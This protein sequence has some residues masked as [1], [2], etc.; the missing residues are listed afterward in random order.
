MQLVVPNRAPLSSEELQRYSRHLILPEVGREGQERL[1]AAKVLLVG[2]GGL[3]SPVAIYLAA[4]GVG[5]IGMVDFDVVDASNLQRQVL[6]FTSDVGK[7]KLQS[8]CEK[9]TAL[10]PNLA[11]VGH[12]TRLTTS[13]ALEIVRGYDVV[14][15]GTDNFP[16]RY[17]VNDACVLSKKPNVYGS[18]YRFDGMAS[19][20]APHLG[21][22]CYRCWYPE[23]PPAG[24]VPSCAEAGVIGVLPGVIGN[25]QA[26][27][28]IKLILGAGEPLLGRLL[29]FNALAMSFREHRIPRDP[30]CP[31][32][33]PNPTIIELK[34][35]P[36]TCS[37]DDISVEQLKAMRERKEDFVLVDV[38]DPDEFAVN[39]IA[40]S[41]KLPLPELPQR[42]GELPKSKLL[43]LHCKAGGRSARALKFL[44]EQGYTRLR[45]LAGGITAWEQRCRD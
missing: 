22:P 24:A 15:D 19:V 37:P 12:E 38:R 13:N 5:T 31:L 9:L 20:F 43:V 32:C 23:P 35:I 7:P 11:F 33:G 27:E 44:R 25:I 2:A 26:T 1:K 17:L 3:G 45:N 40:G 10:N 36:M 30:N 8:A 18:I 34:E 14:V 4:A 29:R 39:E 21:G 28:A 42:F 6:H 16:T 41:V